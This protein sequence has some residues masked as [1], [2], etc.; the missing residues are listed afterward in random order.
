MKK[1][2]KFEQQPK[3]CPWTG[4]LQDGGSGA[5]FHGTFVVMTFLKGTSPSIPGLGC[6]FITLPNYITKS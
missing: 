2:N 6:P 3:A 4:L 5:S 1:F